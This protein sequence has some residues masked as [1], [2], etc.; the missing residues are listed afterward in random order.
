M[1]NTTRVTANALT[2]LWVGVL[3]FSGVGF[4][5][6]PASIPVTYTIATEQDR[7]PISPL[8][9]GS[10]DKMTAAENIP[11]RRSGGN[12]LT[13]YNWENNYSHAGSDWSHYNDDLLVSGFPSAEKLI[14]GRTLTKFQESCNASGQF[15]LIT[16][17]M[18]GYVSADKNKTVTEAEVAPSVRWKEVVFKKPTPFCNP[19]G[20]PN[21]S[22]G[23]VYMDECINFLVSQF[24]NA[25]A[26]GGVK[27]YA[28][29]NEPALWPS[30]H[31]RIHPAK[32]GC[33]ELIDRSVALSSAVKDVDPAAQIFGP[34]LYG[35]AAYNNFQDATDWA[36]VKAGHSYSWFIDYYLDEMKIA[37]NSQGRR[38]LDV[39][40]LHWYPEAQDADGK[41]ITDNQT[42][43]TQ[44]NAEARM[45]A[46]RTLWDPDYV[47]KSWIGQWFRSSLPL[48][49]KITKSI[50]SY[51]PGTKLAMTEYSYGGT[52]HISGGIA[53]ADVLG[54]FGK[55]ELYFASYWGSNDSYISA[56]YKIYRNYDSNK[57]TFGDTRIRASMS[58]K[59]NS[60]VYGSMNA[61]DAETIHLVVLNKNYTQPISGTFNLTSPTPFSSVRVFAFDANSA[62]IT[63][64]VPVTAIFNNSFVYTIPPLTACHF[65][66]RSEQPLGDL[67]GD[68]HVGVEDLLLLSVQWLSDTACSGPACPDLNDDDRVDLLDLA[69]MA[70]NWDAGIPCR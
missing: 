69:L 3:L 45:Q 28:L 46:P 10:N 25:S 52:N 56:A 17:Q 42:V 12:R 15:S 63:E 36:T 1:M 30:T 51:Y 27:A 13:G 70:Q 21:T 2:G 44:T 33:Q 50:K 60:S 57:S 18:A 8:V 4:A 5:A 58:D 22:D 32:T 34:V 66:V 54:I 14:P 47:E 24:G 64:R 20:S 37:S 31:P 38:L 35:F 29:D 40:D 62:A 26:T 6:D 59:V 16:L 48:L 53:M 7:T 19:P 11:A 61:A 49:P 43:Y 55:N 9:Y 23:F 65:V 41:R 67:G 39:L 68:C